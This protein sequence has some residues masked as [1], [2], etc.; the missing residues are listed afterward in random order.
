MR[1]II[2]PAG[3]VCIL[4]AFGV[5]T[6]AALWKYNTAG[7]PGEPAKAL[8]RPTPPPAAAV[9]ASAAAASAAATS[10]SAPA[11]APVKMPPGVLLMPDI[12]SANWKPLI[13]KGEVESDIVSASVPGHP[14]ARR[15]RVTELGE[16]HWDLQLAHPLD[17]PFRK[18]T[19]MRLTYWARSKD[20]CPVG[21]TVEQYAAPYDKVVFKEEKL[22]PEWKQYAEEWEQQAD[23]PPGWAKVDFQVGYKAGEIEI[24]GVILRVAAE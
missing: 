17:A 9:A 20:S 4:G 18:G 10:T 11:A 5:L 21:T 23:T 2:K 7:Q 1:V 14:R 16:N 3:L 8:A 19:R 15:I 13:T 22:T 12:A 6:A 24:T